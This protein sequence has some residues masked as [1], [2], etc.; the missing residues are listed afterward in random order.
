M[1]VM[2][3]G[4]IIRTVAD[5]PTCL[6]HS[7]HPLC[8]QHTQGVTCVMLTGDNIRTGNGVGRALGVS[9]VFA[10]ML[11]ADKVEKVGV[12]CTLCS[13]VKH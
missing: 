9:H 3:T 8:V 1:C 13:K 7:P 10:E 4:D 6:I 11:P 12:Q 2:L 5:K